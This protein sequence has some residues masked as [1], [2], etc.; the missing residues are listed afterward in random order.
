MELHFNNVIGI[1]Q[2]DKK[3]I[4]KSK[5]KIKY[6]FKRKQFK[7]LIMWIRTT[8]GWQFFEVKYTQQGIP[9]PTKPIN[10]KTNLI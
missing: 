7:N 1:N 2:I 8:L 3:N 6:F 5:F 4:I 9:Y 10:S